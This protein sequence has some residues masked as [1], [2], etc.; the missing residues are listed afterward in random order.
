MFRITMAAMLSATVVAC[1]GEASRNG[2]EVDGA[3]T[4]AVQVD[5]SSTVYPITEAVAEEYML[6][7]DGAVRVT[8]GISGTGG[9]FKRFCAGETDIND[10]SRAISA[11]EVESCAAAGVEPLELPVAYDGLSVVVNPANDWAECLTVAELR[12]IWEPG[13]SVT[14]WSQVRA[15]FPDTQL[16]LYGPGT[17]SGTFDYFTE[18]INGEEDASRPDFT[19]SEDDNILVQGVIGDRGALGYFGFAYY[20]ESRDR[21]K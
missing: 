1:G 11:T 19:A 8:V 20:E 4:G 12:A 15:G 3:V 10:A 18:A 13:S 6:A 2:G 9:G 5:G 14:R 17:D 21:L 16:R 7:N